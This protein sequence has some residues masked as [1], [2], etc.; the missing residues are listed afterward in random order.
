MAL[1]I[2]CVLAP[3]LVDDETEARSH[4]GASLLMAC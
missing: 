4:R 3:A 1:E 2:I